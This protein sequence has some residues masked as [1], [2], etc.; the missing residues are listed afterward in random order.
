MKINLSPF[1][2]DGDTSPPLPR[3]IGEGSEVPVHGSDVVPG[4][5]QHL[6]LN[7]V[8][9]AGGQAEGLGEAG[10]GVG[11]QDV[12]EIG[13]HGRFHDVAAGDG[14]AVADVV[15]RLLDHI[16]CAEAV[17]GRDDAVP[18]SFMFGDG[19]ASQDAAFWKRIGHLLQSGDVGAEDVVA[20]DHGASVVTGVAFGACDG[21]A[22]A[23][24]V[25][26]HDELYAHIIV[27][28][29]SV[30]LDVIAD[31]IGPVLEDEGNVPAS[32]G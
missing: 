29:R 21:I 16:G 24:S 10:G 5:F 13:E 22:H 14:D 11:L 27:Q 28:R 9:A 18:V 8:S 19:H 31:V 20:E 17:G 32:G 23:P 25:A 7:A 15:P 6:P 1:G 26:L 2:D 4:A 30:R 3:R 12:L